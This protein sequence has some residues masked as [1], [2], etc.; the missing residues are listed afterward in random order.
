[1]KFGYL[2]VVNGAGPV[3]GNISDYP[4]SWPKIIINYLKRNGYFSGTTLEP[5][6]GRSNLKTLKLDLNAE[7]IPDIIAT[8][9]KLP[10]KDGSFDCALLDPPYREDYSSDL[11]KTKMPDIK[12]CMREAARCLRPR[13]SLSVLCFKN[14]PAYETMIPIEKIFINLGPDRYIRCLNI[15]RIK[16]D[17]SSKLEDYE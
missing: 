8:A 11:Y 15:Y 14:M 6:A 12:E 5:F 1:M 3:Q 10:F 16:K 9:Q 4:G 2:N 17:E 13:G 7:L